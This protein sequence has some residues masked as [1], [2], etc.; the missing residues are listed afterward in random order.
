MPTLTVIKEMQI[1]SHM[2]IGMALLKDQKFIVSQFW[3]LED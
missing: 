1:K 3:S 2:L